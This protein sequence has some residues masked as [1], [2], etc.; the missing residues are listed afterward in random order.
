MP[1]S[2]ALAVQLRGLRETPIVISAWASWCAPCRRQFPLLAVASARYGQRV[3]F[4]SVDVDD[5]RGAA[6]SFL[7]RHPLNYPSFQATVAQ[8]RSILPIA[9]PGLPTTIFL[10]SAGRIFDVHTGAYT[11]PAAL[12]HDIAGLAQA[13][14]SAPTIPSDLKAAFAVFRRPRSPADVL[15]RELATQL[16]RGPALGQ[17]VDPG[18]ARRVGSSQTPAFLVPANG[19]LCLVHGH[20][21]TCIPAREA[22]AGGLLAESFGASTYPE[23]V[24]GVVPD[25]VTNVTFKLIGGGS[26]AVAV[27]GNLYQANLHRRATTMTFTGPSGPVSIAL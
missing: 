9:L 2:R 6:R 21:E 14:G 11:S 5:A 15:P 26:Q 19:G 22:I 16:T 8:L 23:V 7:A 12:D 17:G 3:A 13:S 1:G 4:L 10:N 24:T 20:G 27:H 25:A 18:L